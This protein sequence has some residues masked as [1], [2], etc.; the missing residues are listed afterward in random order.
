MKDRFRLLFALSLVSIFIATGCKDNST[1]PAGPDVEIINETVT[2]NP[3]G[4]APLTALIELETETAVSVSVT[5][6]GINGPESD[7]THSFDQ[8]GRLLE[9]PVL[10][11]YSNIENTVE[12]T[13][14]NSS[15]TNLGTKTYNIDTGPLLA[16]LPE[17]EI[18]TA[19]R[20]QMIGGLNFVSYFG[21][22]VNGEPTPQRP[23]IFDAFGDIRWYLN[24][25]SH[26]NLS[27]LFYDDGMERLQ[28]GN[29]YFGGGNT[30][31]IYEINMLGEIVNT[32]D[33]PG[34]GFHH[35]VKEKPDGN[36]IVT[37]NKFG[38][39]T[40]EDHIIEID[41][42]SGQI[43]NVWDLRESLDQN[44]TAW[45]TNFADISVDWF[46]ANALY[47][48]ETDNTIVVSGRTQGV[49]KL[50][51]N[52]E[53]VWIIAPHKEWATSGDGTDLTQY[54]LQPID[55]GGQEIT[56]QSVLSGDQNHPDFEWSWYQHAPL[57]MPDDNVMLFD[58]GDNRNYGTSPG[59]SRAVEY[60]IDETNMTIQ[61]VWSYGK[62][63][64]NATFS[65]IVSD[66]DYFEDAN[67]VFFIPGAV[68][69]GS[70]YGKTIEIDYDTQ[71]VIFEA[72]ITPP[73]AAF[74]LITLHRTE[75]MPM[76]PK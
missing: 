58:N 6:K 18:N 42:S 31:K 44:R 20:S 8:T 64:G 57:R 13:F 51:G 3:S 47:Y 59:Y 52:N 16:D 10:G 5:V 25:S 56:D 69:S 71:D 28:N 62:N 68:N 54:L 61:Q 35:E 60:D 70:K 15:G 24:F 7:I 40:V 22:R 1:G 38:I 29:L 43:I 66:V 72:T 50:T 48:D 30:N 49:V 14:S 11:L 53:V 23:F 19:D 55:S 41:R 26:P 74:G 39:G 17:I 36:F 2:P 34:Y 76:Y 67:H 65:R 45:D 37:V 21:H 12:L 32:W 27:G 63:R 9:I 4:Y 73:V 46:H 33:M 75:R